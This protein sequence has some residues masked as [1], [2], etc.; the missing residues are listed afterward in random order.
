MS[1]KFTF[2]WLYY[3][4]AIFIKNI[5]HVPNSQTLG[6][7]KNKHI[8]IY[9]ITQWQKRKSLSWT[10][11]FITYLVWYQFVY[12]YSANAANP[13]RSFVIKLNPNSFSEFH[14]V[15]SPARQWLSKNRF[16]NIQFDSCSNES[17][18]VKSSTLKS[19]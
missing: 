4:D 3:F 5:K 12:V 19:N 17:D 9:K 1:L 14:T 10:K 6:E 7:K 16:R 13:T 18:L 8:E 2:H 11:N 15:F